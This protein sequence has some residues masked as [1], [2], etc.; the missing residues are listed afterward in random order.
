MRG[1]PPD[2]RVVDEDGPHATSPR[3]YRAYAEGVRKEYCPAVTTVA[4]FTVGRAAFLSRLL[5][6]P[7]IFH[8]SEGIARWEG[9]ARE[10]IAGELETLKA[11]QGWISRVASSI[12]RWKS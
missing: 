8:T 10:N 5:E 9:P 7:T 3:A 6:Q 11:T 12:L 2:A 1:A 4:R